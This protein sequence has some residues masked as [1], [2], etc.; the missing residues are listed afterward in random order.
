MALTL[1]GAY[2]VTATRLVA[3][4]EALMRNAS[5]R[6][7]H[8]GSTL[9]GQTKANCPKYDVELARAWEGRNLAAKITELTSDITRPDQRRAE[10]RA[11]AQAAMD[12][13][14][15]EL[16]GLP[17]AKVANWMPKPSHAICW[18]LD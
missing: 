13:A 10:Q 6:G 15:G 7:C 11:R 18:R 8:A 3:E 12:K 4:L 14:S 5:Q 2:S 16:A 17:P 9:S 1:S